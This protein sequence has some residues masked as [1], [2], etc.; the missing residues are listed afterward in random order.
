VNL[1]KEA[2]GLHAA[3]KE[4]PIGAFQ[5]W[6][7]YEGADLKIELIVYFFCHGFHFYITIAATVMV[8]AIQCA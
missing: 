4:R 3:G 8:T 2:A 6:T 5:A 7:F 1:V